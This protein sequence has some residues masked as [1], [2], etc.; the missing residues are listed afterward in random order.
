MQTREEIRDSFLAG[1]A[2]GLAALDDR[3]LALERRAPSRME[4]ARPYVEYAARAVATVV[5]RLVE[6]TL[7]LALAALLLAAARWLWFA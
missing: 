7:L 2:A 4:R 6:W 1:I 3:A 5:S